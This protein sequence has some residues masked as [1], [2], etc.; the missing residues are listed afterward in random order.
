MSEALGKF[1]GDKSER[2]R[3][4]AEIEK[5]IQANKKPALKVMFEKGAIPCLYWLFLLVMLNNMFIV[6]YVEYFTGNDFPKVAIDPAFESLLQTVTI[7][8]F[9]KKGVQKVAEKLGK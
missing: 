3:A 7:W 9:G 2:E 8:L 5:A 1:I 4:V 6:P